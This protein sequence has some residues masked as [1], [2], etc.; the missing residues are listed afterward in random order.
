MFFEFHQNNS[1]GSFDYGGDVSEH[2]IIEADSP[3]EANAIAENHGIYFDGVYK[4]MDCEC[5]GNRWY[6]KWEGDEGTE[7]PT[8]YGEKLTKTAS[9]PYVVIYK[10]GQVERNDRNKFGTAG[11]TR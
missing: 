10:S 9:R 3:E 6:P 7:E 11:G 1:G 2:V 4:D 5:C 8:I